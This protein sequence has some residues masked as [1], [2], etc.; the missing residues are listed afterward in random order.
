M[1]IGRQDKQSVQAGITN[2]SR[3]GH[4]RIQYSTLEFNIVQCSKAQLRQE[5]SRIE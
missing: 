1:L 5:Q 2:G 4:M 3:K